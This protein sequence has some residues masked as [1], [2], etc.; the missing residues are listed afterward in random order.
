MAQ[1]G[2]PIVDITTQRS[3][4]Q[5]NNEQT[6]GFR[7]TWSIQQTVITGPISALV[8][9]TRDTTQ[10]YAVDAEDAGYLANFSKA[11]PLNELDTAAHR[12]ALNATLP[13]AEQV[14]PTPGATPDADVAWAVARMLR[15]DEINRQR[16]E[17]PTNA[18]GDP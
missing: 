12:A 6:R 16:G 8:S 10:A 1:V 3:L 13:P 11:F 2:D 5:G 18:A 9:T 17:I 14:P 15:D 7:T 4:T